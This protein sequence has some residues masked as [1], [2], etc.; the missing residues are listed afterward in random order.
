M[1]PVTFHLVSVKSSSGFLSAVRD[2]PPTKCPLYLG[3]CKHWIH[4]PTLSRDALT[5]SSDEMLQWDY[6]FIAKASEQSTFE[7]A[8]TIAK[9][10]TAHWAITAPVSDEHLDALDA[11]NEQRRAAPIPS[12]PVGWSPSD[13][14]GLV[15]AEP[16]ADLEASLALSSIPLGA[17]ETSPPTDL[18]TFIRTFGT[19]HQGP[20]S[21][22]NL[23]AYHPGQR[24][25]YFQ[26]I[27]AFT[28]SVGSRYGGQPQFIGFGGVDWSS[29]EAEGAKVADPEAG[30]SG[31]WEDTALVWYP[32]IW[33]FGKMLDDPD[34][35]AVDRRFKQ[36]ALM[37]NP[38]ICCTEVDLECC[39]A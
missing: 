10:T 1:A 33:H 21:M 15:A 17:S 28:E 4:S 18:K 11:A 26:Y 38:L 2:L 30:G 24:S 3:H 16:P 39:S 19:T 35:A 7:L 13:H 36:G 32:S 31:V 29:R 6:L 12:L 8:S 34:Y 14:G 5:G 27:A 25:R 23:L 9:H 20:V 37:D 22:F